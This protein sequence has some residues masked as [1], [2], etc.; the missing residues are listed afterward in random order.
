MR[1]PFSVFE[2]RTP[3]RYISVKVGSFELGGPSQSSKSGSSSVGG[4]LFG[5]FGKQLLSKTGSG[6]EVTY[7]LC[8]S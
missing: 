5:G 1:F 4:S 6:G 7:L 3:M 8:S 2:N